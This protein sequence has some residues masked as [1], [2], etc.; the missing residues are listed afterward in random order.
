MFF[1]WW[2]PIKNLPLLLNG[3]LVSLWI[4][5]VVFILSLALGT[6]VG[7][8]RFNRSR[9]LIYGAATVYVEIIRN[10]PLLVQIFFIYFGLP[11]FN[12]YLPALFAGIVGLTINTSAYVAEIIRSGIQSVAKGQREAADCIALSKAMVFCDI[13][14]PQALRN[15]FP[16]LINQF[17]MILFATSLLSVLDIKDLTQRASILN[18]QNFRTVEIYVFAVIIYYVLALACSAVL[19]YIN[20]RF[21]PSISQRG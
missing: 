3:A 17:I 12:I 6:V 13:V 20:N 19:R 11:Q 15:I 10:T 21:F 5:V 2:T 14:L 18:S 9:T 8:L 16:S 7:I 4:T 1:D